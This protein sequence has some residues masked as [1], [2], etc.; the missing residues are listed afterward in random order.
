MD[1]ALAII[2]AA[3]DKDTT[4]VSGFIHIVVLHVQ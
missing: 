1:C 2:G 3:I 4:N